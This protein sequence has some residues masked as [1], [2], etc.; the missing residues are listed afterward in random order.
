MQD[1]LF[2]GL[3]KLNLKKPEPGVGPVPY[4]TPAPAFEMPRKKFRCINQ[5]GKMVY[6]HKGSHGSMSFSQ[7]ADE[8]M[9]K[10]ARK[11][12]CTVPVGGLKATRLRNGG[13]NCLILITYGIILAEQ[14]QINRAMQI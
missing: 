14:M 5:H 8:K 1:Y 7:F 3:I 2:G 6:R 11:I 12:H 4:E 9:K 13:V 10:Q